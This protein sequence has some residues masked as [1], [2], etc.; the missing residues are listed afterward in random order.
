MGRKYNQR[1]YVLDGA[2]YEVDA[3]LK[4]CLQKIYFSAYDLHNLTFLTLLFTYNKIIFIIIYNN[5]N[6]Q[7]N[8]QKIQ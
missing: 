8:F 2:F 5:L 1:F 3:S 6:L 7:F 4:A